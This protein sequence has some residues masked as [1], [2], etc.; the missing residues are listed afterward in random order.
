[1]GELLLGPQDVLLGEVGGCPFYVDREQYERWR[2][3]LILIDVAPGGGDSFS[4]EG[5]EGIHF[6]ARTPADP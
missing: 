6:V 5:A 3:P 1:V 4:V 2:K